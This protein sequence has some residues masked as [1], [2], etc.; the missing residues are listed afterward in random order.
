MAGSYGSKFEAVIRRIKHLAAQGPH[1]KARG[2]SHCSSTAQRP[3]APPLLRFDFHFAKEG[4][5]G[6]GNGDEGPGPAAD[7]GGRGLLGHP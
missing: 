4:R 6:G 5:V 1:V 2:A 3:V 7:P